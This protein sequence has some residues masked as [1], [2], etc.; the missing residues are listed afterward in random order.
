MGKSV[1]TC[2]GG[3]QLRN[4]YSRLESDLKSSKKRHAELIDQCNALK[5][6]R[7][8][9]VSVS[10]LHFFQ[11]LELFSTLQVCSMWLSSC[12]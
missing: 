4:V 2:L 3:G 7:E 11:R 5:K 9:S 8:D 10:K 6:G 12:I 1:V